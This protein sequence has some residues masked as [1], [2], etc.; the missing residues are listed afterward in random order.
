MVKGVVRNVAPFGL[1]V[2]LARRLDGL[3]PFDR[4]PHPE[5]ARRARVGDTL[6]VLVRS[7]DLERVRVFLELVVDSA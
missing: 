3:L 6:D 7:V 1:F 5:I 2:E 4:T